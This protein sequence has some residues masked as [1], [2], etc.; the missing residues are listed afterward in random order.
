MTQQ[1]MAPA[2]RMVEAVDAGRITLAVGHE[3]L[4]GLEASGEIEPGNVACF[5]EQMNLTMAGLIAA[6]GGKA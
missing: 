1:G 2:R 3:S 5:R 6:W 4:M